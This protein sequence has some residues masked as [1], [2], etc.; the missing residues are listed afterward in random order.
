MNEVLKCEL[1]L[2]ISNG[3]G[4]GGMGEENECLLCTYYVPDLGKV[5]SYIISLNHHDN[6]IMKRVGAHSTEE[7][8]EAQR[9]LCMHKSKQ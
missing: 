6:T 7:K 2:V 1:T 5:F 4:R 3:Q 8:T 9:V